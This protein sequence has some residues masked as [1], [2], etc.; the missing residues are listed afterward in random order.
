VNAPP[1]REYA[2]MLRGRLALLRE[3]LLLD[4]YRED[5]DYDPDDENENQLFESWLKR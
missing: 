2:N 3:H 4:Q 1:T 5:L